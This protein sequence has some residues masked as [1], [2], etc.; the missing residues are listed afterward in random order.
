MN[1]AHARKVLAGY[2]DHY[3]GHR[4]H[5]S[6]DQRLPDAQEQ[7]A[8]VRGLNDRRLLRNRILGGAIN[9]CRYAA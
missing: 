8:A 9:E 6:R 7:L 5:P 1:E 2:H 3:N 4:P